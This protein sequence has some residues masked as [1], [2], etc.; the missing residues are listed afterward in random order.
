MADLSRLLRPTS[1]AVIGGGWGLAVVQECLKM[2]FAGKIW[3]V[4]PTRS[5]IEGLP[6]Y[7]SL[8]ALPAA[9][10]A[11][12]VAVNRQATVDVVGALS[13]MGAGG[14]VCF[15]SGFAE[16]E[17]DRAAGAALQDRLVGAARAMPLIGPNCYGL[18]NY[19]D[20]ALLW[21][22]QHGGRPRHSG[23]ALLTQSSNVLINLTMQRR[24][25]P[26]AYCLTAGNQAQT[27]LPDLARAVLTDDRVTALGIHV[28][29]ISDVS[30]W[31]E[32]ATQ[33]RRANKPIVALKVGR[34]QQAQAATVSH[35]ASLAGDTAASSAFFRRLGI[36]EVR[37][38]PE[39]L[40]TLK[41]LHVHGPLP[42]RAV[43]SMSCSGGEA[44]LI[45]DAAEG[46]GVWFPE[47]QPDHARA[48]RETLSDMVTIANPLD[49]HTF[50]W[51]DAARMAETYSAVV[52]GPFDL[53]LLVYDYPRADRTE[54][55]AWDCGHDAIRSAQSRTGARVAVV[56]S[57]PDTMDEA[58]ADELM[59]AGIAPL[60]GFD[61]ALGA[62][63][64]AAAV[65]D[66]WSLPTPEALLATGSA[67][68]GSEVLEEAEA[69]ALL[70]A[71]GLN[72]PA[73]EAVSTPHDAAV[74]AGTMGFPVVLKGMG[75]GHKTEAGAVKLNL[76]SAEA[77]QAAA[78]QMQTMNGFLV[79]RMI[80]GAV[81][82]LIV[83]IVKSPP[84]GYA[85]VLGAG[86]VLT[87]LLDETRTLLLPAPRR[88]VEEALASLKVGKILAGYRGRAAADRD[89]VIDAIMA[90]QAFV[91][92]LDGALDELDINPLIA[93]PD[94]AYVADALMRISRR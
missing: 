86:G 19:L 24:G 38:L 58:R 26:I 20:R 60:C 64:R 5:K 55:A 73:G 27:G 81:A 65:H 43:S 68:L 15:A 10:D 72:V 93:T 40:E 11:A 62:V 69:K 1:I 46:T 44:S 39:M 84:Y 42:G 36:A 21:P 78:S 89:A 88:D 18:I 3:P 35:T 91:A 32:M 56:S 14:A 49:Y 57:L 23:V 94:G 28:E 70:S 41:L 71:A 53:N 13:A 30:A 33:A 12:F 9:P 37:T 22:D 63:D 8:S 75:I 25:V 92:G 87:E 52:S 79:E 7:P 67:D 85:L 31:E 80:A 50:V 2:G 66:A 4:H 16:A 76:E 90:V 51:G 54:T 83:G 45:A 6:C 34:S 29:G 17:D 82:E 74:V 47:L 77:V 61:E 59:A 48:V